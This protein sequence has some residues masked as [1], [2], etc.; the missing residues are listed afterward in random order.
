MKKENRDIT[1]RNLSFQRNIFI[2]LSLLLSISTASLAVLQFFKNEK[3]IVVPPVIQE[4][5]WVDS[6]SVS[7]SYLEQLGLYIGQLLLSKTADSSES[8]KEILLKHTHA[9]FAG[10][11]DK[12]LKEEGKKMKEE[13]TSYAFFPL[14]VDVHQDSFE[15]DVSGDRTS[16]LKDKKLSSK[17]ETYRLIFIY[18]GGRLLLAGI[19]SGGENGVS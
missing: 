9:S 18:S 16:Y 12:K 13:G 3:V 11:L 7:P 10:I 1:L 2:F 5:F 4:G 19:R 6:K 17:K 15:V 14:S 8:Q